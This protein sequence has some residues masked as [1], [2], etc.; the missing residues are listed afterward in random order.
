[1]RT[2]GL[3]LPAFITN[4]IQEDLPLHKCHPSLHFEA[5]PFMLPGTA[6]QMVMGPHRQKITCGVFLSP[7]EWYVDGHSRPLMVRTNRGLKLDFG[8]QQHPGSHIPSTQA[9]AIFM[10]MF[11]TRIEDEKTFS[12]MVRKM[13]SRIIIEIERRCLPRLIQTSTSQ[14]P[15]QFVD[16]PSKYECSTCHRRFS[17]FRGRKRHSCRIEVGRVDPCVGRVDPCVCRVD[18]CVG[19]VEPCVGRVD[20]SVGRVDPCVGRV[21]PCVGRV[22]P[23]VGRVGDIPDPEPIPVTGGSRQYKCP[24]CLCGFS[25]FRGRQRHVCCDP[26]ADKDFVCGICYKLYTSEARL[27]NHRKRCHSPSPTPSVESTTI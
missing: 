27:T 18:P 2:R 13:D 3:A 1:M 8:L 16:V 24:S 7:S 20:P 17:S 15:S 6:F 21:D 5:E 14:L 11:V 19:R 10:T 26:E 22:D 9:Q 23:C 12:D 25:S 4:T